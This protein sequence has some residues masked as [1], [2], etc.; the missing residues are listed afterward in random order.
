MA[1]ICAG[2]CHILLYCQLK[3]ILLSQFMTDMGFQMENSVAGSRVTFTPNDP[4]LSSKASAFPF[5]ITI[6]LMVLQPVTFHRRESFNTPSLCL[7]TESLSY[8]SP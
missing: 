3:L 7:I 4:R 5:T 8:S 2:K 6:D 1:A